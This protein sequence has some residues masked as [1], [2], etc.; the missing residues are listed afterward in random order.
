MTLSDSWNLPS[1]TFRMGMLALRTYPTKCSVKVLK[2]D[3]NSRWWSL[4]KAGWERALSLILYSWRI[5]MLTRPMKVRI[6][7]HSEFYVSG[8]FLINYLLL[9]WI[10]YILIFLIPHFN[11]TLMDFLCRWSC[12]IWKDH[13]RQC[14]HFWNERR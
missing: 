14:I 11:T 12:E 10:F 6:L 1:Y 3:F 7:I 4:E 13:E 5:S 8:T 2:K 9:L